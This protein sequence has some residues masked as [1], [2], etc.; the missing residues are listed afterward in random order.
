MN[1]TFL[2]DN[3]KY[4]KPK[5]QNILIWIDQIKPVI[6]NGE[7][8]NIYSENKLVTGPILN[9]LFKNLYVLPNCKILLC[10]DNLLTFLPLLPKCQGLDCS[11]NELTFL[12][13][14]QNCK[15]LLCFNNKLTKLPELNN[16]SQLSCSNNLLEDLVLLPNCQWLE[17]NFNK[18]KYIP[19]LPSCTDL[20]CS[21]NN[22]T[23]LTLEQVKLCKLINY[24]NNPNLICSTKFI[25]SFA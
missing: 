25:E 12:P 20:D 18:L 2:I 11:D 24:D 22:L 13:D 15:K 7:Y 1:I 23:S 5:N 4:K 17:C 14:L 6:L 19:N 3:T 8:I 21:N 16:C 9:K 10:N